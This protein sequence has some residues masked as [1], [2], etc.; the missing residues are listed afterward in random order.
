MITIR[1]AAE[2]DSAALA[3]F[4]ARTFYDTFAKDNTPENMSAYLA[5]TFSP[6][7]QARELTDPSITF[8]IAEDGGTIAGSVKVV[9]GLAPACITGRHPIEIARLYVDK[10]YFRQGI[11][12]RLMQCCF[13]LAASKG[14]DTVWLGVW[15]HNDRAREFYRKWKFREVGSH[16][17]QLGDD[18]QID[19]LL[20][21]P[22]T[23]ML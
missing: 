21:R 18:P 11:G 9:D 12:T 17:F 23:G 1:R 4:G 8:F 7:K 3:E 13:D 16:I 2:A 10:Q 15:E 22:L 6:E 20:Q 5:L 19:L 14:C